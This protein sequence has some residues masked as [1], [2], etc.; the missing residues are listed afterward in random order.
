VRNGINLSLYS[1]NISFSW[2]INIFLNTL[3]YSVGYLVF[4]RPFLKVFKFVILGFAH[5]FLNILGKVNYD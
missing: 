3:R 2:R 5:G 4:T 1:K